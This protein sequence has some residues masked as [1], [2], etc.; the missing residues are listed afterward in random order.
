MKRVQEQSRIVLEARV[1]ASRE[2]CNSNLA[3]AG[4][5]RTIHRVEDSGEF[6][7]IHFSSRLAIRKFLRFPDALIRTKFIE[8]A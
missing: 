2:S 3:T 8:I 4:E 7:R 1:F 6:L 5:Q